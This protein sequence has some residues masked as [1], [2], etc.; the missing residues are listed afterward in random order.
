MN[1][2]CFFLNQCR[3]FLLFKQSSFVLQWFKSL[4]G[5]RITENQ[6]LGGGACTLFSFFNFLKNNELLYYYYYYL[7]VCVHMCTCT[8]IMWGGLRTTFRI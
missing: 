8:H 2:S 5:L 7:R 4:F 6:G 1:P 3:P